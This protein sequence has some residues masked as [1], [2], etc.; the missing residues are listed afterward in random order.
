MGDVLRELCP[1]VDFEVS[2]VFSTAIKNH[3]EIEKYLNNI[4]FP[5]T[6]INGFPMFHGV[7]S[8]KLI[9]CIIDENLEKE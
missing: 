7:L 3:P 6:A 2:D 8:L 9:A 1:L 5:L 4:K